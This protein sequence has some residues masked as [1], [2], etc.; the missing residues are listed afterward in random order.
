MDRT[1][2]IVG[3]GQ[4][5]ARA[6]KAMRGA[7]FDGRV[8]IVGDEAHHPYERPM[9]SKALLL[10]P[11]MPV[12][13]VLPE[14][15]YAEAGIEVK[16][17]CR[18]VE[19]H[20]EARVVEL[21]DG[22]RLHYDTLLLATGSSIRTLA[23]P[24]VADEAIWTLRTLDDARRLEAA[25]RDK[26]SVAVIGGGF[27]GLEVAASAAT[28]GC[29]ASV[30]ETADRLLPRLGCP[31]ASRAVLDH[32]RSRGI[33]VRLG[34]SVE[35]GEG[36]TLLL[37]DGAAARADII[38]AGI[39][40]TPN[41]ALAEAA[42]LDVDDGILVDEYGRT[43]DPDIFAA[44]DVT[45]H[46]NPALGRRVR[47]ESWQNANAQAEAAARTIA[48]VPTA[49]TEVPW[50]WSDQ[51]DLNLQIAGAPRAVDRAIVRGNSAADDG[52]SVFQFAGD[53]LVGGV[54]LNRGKEMPLIRRMLAQP[55][56]T[57]DPVAL[58]D[59]TVPLRRL[60][61]AREAA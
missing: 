56:L 29:A 60:M 53:H 16:L 41:T 22:N 17:G 1:V 12:P 47:L 10:D 23:I 57:I 6:A 28:L 44:G 11:A 33:D 26:P 50:V 20:R 39:G 24:G 19:I 58:A 7:G 49:S 37:S 3:G 38:V 21:Q 59:P 54:T 48:G 14:Q 32:H 27:I 42:G 13:F 2:V 8:V 52:M 9:L 36:D 30:I 35:R 46:F 18:A 51:G 55:N 5:A 43:S 4:A 15:G 40:V 45:R 31:E 25:L 61:P 34:V